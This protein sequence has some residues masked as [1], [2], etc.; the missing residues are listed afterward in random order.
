MRV[1]DIKPD[2]PLFGYVR[3]GHHLVS[4]NGQTVR[5]SLD[6]QFLASDEMVELVFKDKKGGEQSFRFDNL[7][8][9]ALGLV[10]E[11]EKVRRCRCNCIFCFVR[12]QP[13]RMRRSL[14]VRDEDYRLSFTHGNYVTLSNRGTTVFAAVCVGPHYRRRIAP[15]HARQQATRANPAAP[16]MAGR[17]G[18]TASHP[19]SSLP[20][21][22]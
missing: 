10:F 3:A 16:E 4:V 22:E 14:Y 2:S 5:D 12:Q 9:G 8:P 15:S 1:A 7:Y 13:P 19:G 6:F 20:G 17:A 18:D 21:D 11:D